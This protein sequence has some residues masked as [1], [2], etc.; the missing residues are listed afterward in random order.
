MRGLDAQPMAPPPPMQ[1]A[2][3]PPM[4]APPDA[5]GHQ[6]I[7]GLAQLATAL[8]SRMMQPGAGAGPVD[9]PMRRKTPFGEA[10]SGQ[11]PYA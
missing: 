8:Q 1:F 4:L 6:A 7:G 9:A 3:P 5:T 10:A 11:L 2:A